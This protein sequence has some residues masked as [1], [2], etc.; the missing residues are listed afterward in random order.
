MRNVTPINA[1]RYFGG[2]MMATEHINLATQNGWPAWCGELY[3]NSLNDP[4]TFD[5]VRMQRFETASYFLAATVH[6]SSRQQSLPYLNIIENMLSNSQREFDVPLFIRELFQNALDVAE[7]DRTLKIKLNVSDNELI[8]EHNGR[9]FIGPRSASERFGEMASLFDAGSTTKRADFSSEGRFGIGF[10]GWTRFFNAISIEC[11]DDDTAVSIGWEFEGTRVIN[12]Q[13]SGPESDVRI[14]ENITKYTFYKPKATYDN[15]GD[16]DNVVK[17]RQEILYLAKFAECSVEVEFTHNEGSELITHTSEEINTYAGV[18]SQTIRK[19]KNE[20]SI[21]SDNFQELLLCVD[22]TIPPPTGEPDRDPIYSAITEYIDHERERLS[23]F[24]VENPWDNVTEQDWYNAKKISLAV[25]YQGSFAEITHVENEGPWWL[26][27]LAPIHTCEGWPPNNDLSMPTSWCANGPFFIEMNRNVMKSDPISKKANATL[28]KSLLKNCAGLLSSTLLAREHNLHHLLTGSSPFDELIS[29]QNPN[30]NTNPFDEIL[31]EENRQKRGYEQVFGGRPFFAGANSELID[32][33][34]ARR[35]PQDW[36]LGQGAPQLMDWLESQDTDII[37]EFWSDIPFNLEAEQFLRENDSQLTKL[38]Q[39]IEMQE[40]YD[41]LASAGLLEVLIENYPDV[42][43]QHWFSPPLDGIT[44]VVFDSA[45]PHSQMLVILRRYCEEAGVEFEPNES[46]INAYRGTN[47]IWEYDERG[48]YTLTVPEQTSIDDWSNHLL[49]ILN[50]LGSYL[51]SVEIE[52]ISDELNQSNSNWF[53]AKCILQ[54]AFGGAIQSSQKI[55]AI[56]PRTVSRQGSWTLLMET[57]TGWNHL[58]GGGRSTTQQRGLWNTISPNREKI[59]IL[60]QIHFQRDGT[61]AFRRMLEVAKDTCIVFDNPINPE[62][63]VRSVKEMVNDFASNRQG[64]VGSVVYVSPEPCPP[65]LKSQ[66]HQEDWTKIPTIGLVEISGIDMNHLG[67][68]GV[69]N[70]RQSTHNTLR[71]NWHNIEED[72]RDSFYGHSMLL[73]TPNCRVNHARI[74]C[75]IREI[76]FM[77]LSNS[78]EFNRF[79]ARHRVALRINQERLSGQGKML[80]YQVVSA[81]RRSQQSPYRLMRADIRTIQFRSQIHEHYPMIEQNNIEH[82]IEQGINCGLIDPVEETISVWLPCFEEQRASLLPLVTDLIDLPDPLIIH[83]SNISVTK[84]PE[85]EVLRQHFGEGVKILLEKLV[86]ME[87]VNHQ[88]LSDF[89][90]YLGRISLLLDSEIQNPELIFIMMRDLS[91]NTQEGTREQAIRLFQEALSSEENSDCRDLIQR[92]V[93]GIQ[94]LQDISWEEI[95]R[96]IRESIES[97]EPALHQWNI[98]RDGGLLP[99][100]STHKF[101]RDTETFEVTRMRNINPR[102]QY[103]DEDNARRLFHITLEAEREDAIGWSIPRDQYV[104]IIHD[105]I[106]QMLTADEARNHV[107]GIWDPK[108]VIDRVEPLGPNVPH[109]KWSYVQALIAISIAKELEDVDGDIRRYIPK[110]TEDVDSRRCQIFDQNGPEI[111]IGKYGWDLRI[112]DEEDRPSNG[113]GKISL[114]CRSV[115]DSSVES[116]FSRKTMQALLQGLEL[117]LAARKSLR[118]EEGRENIAAMMEIDVNFIQQL[119]NQ[120]NEDGFDLLNPFNRDEL[121]QWLAIHTTPQDISTDMNRSLEQSDARIL[122]DDYTIAIRRL[123][124]R[125][126]MGPVLGDECQILISGLRV[127]EA[128]RERLYPDGGS[129][130]SEE[131][132]L[133][134]PGDNVTKMHKARRNDRYSTNS[135][136]LNRMETGLDFVGNVLWLSP[137]SQHRMSMTAQEFGLRERVERNISDAVISLLQSNEWGPDNYIILRDVMQIGTNNLLSIKIHKYHAI[138]MAAMDLALEKL[139]INEG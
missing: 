21:D 104:S 63:L 61:P 19:I 90:C 17:I 3:E 78:Q 102:I 77:R 52:L 97:D 136:N 123:I 66:L 98:F 122:L 109:Q 101:E 51:S 128:L 121:D 93:N 71:R 45:P 85:D 95:Q 83:P 127:S 133:N 50:K 72:K 111:R 16:I 11:S 22:C 94:S 80:R 113:H 68:I 87:D 107:Y 49:S 46:I 38:I 124:E 92:V 7:P 9:I 112:V 42:T 48:V 15:D 131:P 73:H 118:T 14:D 70:Q 27:S 79:D 137:F 67:D 96:R 120:L 57:L 75:L 26:H 25:R 12:P 23:N 64:S 81:H 110:I 24:N 58:G 84:L 74:E 91:I 5:D 34:E 129:M 99:P 117:K 4:T 54:L 103:I 39:A 69:G 47:Q 60:N 6:H 139:E 138:I 40:M 41:R 119:H 86:E 126:D 62:C 115:E 56:I 37:S 29:T 53:A 108:S 135:V 55:C 31:F 32:V 33:F 10:K 44:A 1:S 125:E 36:R 20:C 13:F 28:I 82:L 65:S 8:W 106:A 88:T 76:G 100:S 130:I 132:T 105:D 89:A 59:S 134:I 114:S 2:S 18:P 43:Q 116:R 30:P 35:I